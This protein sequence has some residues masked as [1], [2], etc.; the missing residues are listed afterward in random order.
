ME[1]PLSSENTRKSVFVTIFKH[2]HL[3]VF[4]QLTQRQAVARPSSKRA[5][6]KDSETVQEN[7][8]EEE[9]VIVGVG[10]LD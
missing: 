6:L 7:S 1:L 5:K 4:K 9:S 2:Y 10:I 8:K 3:W